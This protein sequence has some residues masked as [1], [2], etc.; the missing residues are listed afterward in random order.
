MIVKVFLAIHSRCMHMIRFKS[1]FLQQ[2]TQFSS[3]LCKVHRF[4]AAMTDVEN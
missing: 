3:V 2:K 4:V 1:K